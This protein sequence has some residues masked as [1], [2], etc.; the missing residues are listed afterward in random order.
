M[1]AIWRPVAMVVAGL[2]HAASIGSPWDGQPVGWLQLL[3]LGML[4]WQLRGC[5]SPRQ[6]AW[7]GWL[8]TTAWLCGTFWWLYVAMHTY[9][10][11]A[12][13]LAAIAVFALA[14]MLALYYACA[15]ALFVSLFVGVARVN[16]AWSAAVFASLFCL[17][18]AFA[19]P[20][21]CH[22]FREAKELQ[23]SNSAQISMKNVEIDDFLNL[24]LA[25]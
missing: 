4:A 25:F 18:R 23:N 1:K 7:L 14:G 2:A 17:K 20:Q 5:S 21:N 6:G 9:G 8:F 15:C 16:K 10:G 11:L 22:P 19:K 3:A 24:N 12:A 13:P